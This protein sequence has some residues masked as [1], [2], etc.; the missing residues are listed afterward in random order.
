M[1]DAIDW[2]RFLESLKAPL[3]ACFRLN[4]NYAFKG[5]LQQEL[6][7]FSQ[8]IAAIA[9]AAA[10]TEGDGSVARPAVEQIDWFQGGNAYKLGADR[11]AIR[12]MEVCRMPVSHGDTHLY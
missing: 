2:D 4:P 9:P 1:T 6:F 5:K 12:K 11:R 7:E 3:P 8:S 10:S